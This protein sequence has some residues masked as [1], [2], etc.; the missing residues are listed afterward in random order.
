MQ[1]QIQPGK[2]LYGLAGLVV[3]LGIV[4]F[5]WILMSSL[6]GIKNSL[7][8]FIMPG[9]A[10]L[11]LKQPG[12]HTIY[13]ERTSVVGDRVFATGENVSG[14]KCTV[15]S[16]TAGGNLELG[17]PGMSETYT[18]GS[19]SGRSVL[20]FTTVNPGEFQLTCA[21]LNG[22]KQPEVVFALGHD[23]MSGFF[24]TIALCF[25]ALFGG[26]GLG[27]LIFAVTLVR[28]RQAMSRW[29]Q[30]GASTPPN[31]LTKD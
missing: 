26:I 16:L 30:S 25:A 27:T 19:R 18:F 28:R 24:R 31:I 2:W 29:N 14:I 22:A 15:T 6:N 9:S 13:Y 10:E 8:Q 23:F 11:S 3:S 1:Q 5:I 20:E 17:E 12:T 21:Y 4:G 7:T